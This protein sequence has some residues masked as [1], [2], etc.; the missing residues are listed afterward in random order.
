[1]TNEYRKSYPSPSPN[2]IFEA[3]LAEELTQDQC[4][5]LCKVT[6]RAW[7]HWELGIRKMPAACWELFKIKAGK[8]KN[9]L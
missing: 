4:A 6:K 8:R 9:K 3:R 1:M 5:I 7:G 2:E